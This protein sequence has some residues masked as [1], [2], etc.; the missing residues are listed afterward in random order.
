M[1]RDEI[2]NNVLLGLV[3]GIP[4]VVMVIVGMN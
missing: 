1:D 2:K 4:V 3:F